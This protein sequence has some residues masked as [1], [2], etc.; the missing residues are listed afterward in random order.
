MAGLT[1]RD[2]LLPTPTGA[3]PDGVA[4][5]RTMAPDGG[6]PWRGQTASGKVVG[7]RGRYA[8]DAE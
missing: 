1:E 6:S 4:V 3:L 2:T 8:G 5:R 7:A